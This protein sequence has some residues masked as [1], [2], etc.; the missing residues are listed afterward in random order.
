MSIPPHAHSSDD[1]QDQTNEHINEEPAIEAEEVTTSPDTEDR[2]EAASNE[3]SP[4]TEAELPPEAQGEANGGPLGCCLGMV[5][6]VLL[7]ALLILLL[8]FAGHFSGQP[9]FPL[10]LVGAVICG[11]L[12]WRIGRKIYREYEVPPPLPIPPLPPRKRKVKR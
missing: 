2:G 7:T 6:G 1:N 10:T 9:F 3:S 5:V 4:S 8:A 11:F 12:G